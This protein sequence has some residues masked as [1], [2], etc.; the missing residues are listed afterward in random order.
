VRVA[1][2]L[3]CPAGVIWG[4][5]KQSCAVEVIPD[6]SLFLPP[7]SSLSSPNTRESAIDFPVCG[8]E[9]LVQCQWE[10]I[11]NDLVEMGDCCTNL[12]SL[13]L[14]SAEGQKIV[15]EALPCP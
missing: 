5:S 3:A 1:A 10:A 14:D 6:Q 8:F 2:A 7:A 12:Q 13:L 11:P 9:G 4:V 15:K